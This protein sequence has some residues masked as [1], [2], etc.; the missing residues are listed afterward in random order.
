MCNKKR[1][2]KSRLLLKTIGGLLPTI[3]A[4]G[5]IPIP[6]ESNIFPV[7]VIKKAEKTG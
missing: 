7:I 1:R 5:W 2:R 6:S 3:R 4:L